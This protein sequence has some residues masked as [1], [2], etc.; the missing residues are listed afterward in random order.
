[1]VICI[2]LVAL[3][4]RRWRPRGAQHTQVAE[5]NRAYE[6]LEHTADHAIGAE[7]NRNYDE[8]DDLPTPHIDAGVVANDLEDYAEAS[9]LRQQ[10]T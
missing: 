8:D 1:V 3:A 7:N 6:G 2:I 9:L 10:D 5:F 4:Y